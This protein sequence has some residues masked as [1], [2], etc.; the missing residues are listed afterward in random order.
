LDKTDFHTAL[1][2]SREIRMGLE[3]LSEERDKGVTG[4]DSV[5]HDLEGRVAMT[6]PQIVADF[7]SLETSIEAQDVESM[8]EHETLIDGL[9]D[10]LDRSIEAVDRG[11]ITGIRGGWMQRLKAWRESAGKLAQLLCQID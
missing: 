2:L 4:K 6:L 8:L 7:E 5:V 9:V 1:Y 11:E 10:A 3:E